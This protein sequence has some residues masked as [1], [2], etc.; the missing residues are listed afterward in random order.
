MKALSPRELRGKS[1]DDLQA[2]LDKERAALFE[3]RRKLAFREDKDV[4]KVK[5]RRHNIARILTQ[6]T[7]MKRGNP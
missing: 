3:D 2:L 6:I 7:E 5:S 1:L 4:N